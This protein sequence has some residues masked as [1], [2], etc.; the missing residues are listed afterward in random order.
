MQVRAAITKLSTILGMVGLAGK[1]KVKQQAPILKRRRKMHGPTGWGGNAGSPVTSTL[2]AKI[3]RLVIGLAGN[4]QARLV[5]VAT[6][7]DSEHT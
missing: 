2:E 7:G 1:G 4:Q 3:G 5:V 6:L